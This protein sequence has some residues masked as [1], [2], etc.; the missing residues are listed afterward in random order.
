MVPTW[1]NSVLFMNTGPDSG[2]RRVRRRA[3]S[4]PGLDATTAKGRIP[5]VVSLSVAVSEHQL[6]PTRGLEGSG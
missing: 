5:S 1:C 3:H 6:Q 2:E 4:A